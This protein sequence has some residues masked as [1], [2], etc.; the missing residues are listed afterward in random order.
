MW[1]GLETRMLLRAADDRLQCRSV[2]H[3]VA[4]PLI[5]DGWRQGKALAEI[6]V[7]NTDRHVISWI[8][9]INHRHC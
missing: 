8:C 4:N 1:T 2:V 9:P 7:V 5:K 6:T 3:G